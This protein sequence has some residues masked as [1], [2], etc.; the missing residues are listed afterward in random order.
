MTRSL[1]MFALLVVLVDGE[2]GPASSLGSS[3][4]SALDGQHPLVPFAHWEPPGTWE[5][6]GSFEPPERHTVRWLTGHDPR[7][8]PD[9]VSP[10]GL[11][12]MQQ[13]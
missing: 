2:A 8:S 11:Q 3:K 5:N 10:R 13:W 9:A 7:T 4:G 12:V 6:G 1:G